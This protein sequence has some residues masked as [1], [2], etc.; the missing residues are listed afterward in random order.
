M[1][2]DKE[3]ADKVRAQRERKKSREGEGGG[4]SPFMSFIIISGSFV[5]ITS[6]HVIG[7]TATRLSPVE[8]HAAARQEL[9]GKTR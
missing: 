7:L 5:F 4:L 6:R 2:L 1:K 9:K 3:G 8:Q